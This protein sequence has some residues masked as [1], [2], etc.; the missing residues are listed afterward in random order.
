MFI[1]GHKYIRS[2]VKERNQISN[3]HKVVLH[4]LITRKTKGKHFYNTQTYFTKFHKSFNI[5]K[6][7][8]RL[9]PVFLTKTCKHGAHVN[10]QNKLVRKGQA[11]KIKSLVFLFGKLPTTVF[12]MQPCICKSVFV[13][14]VHCCVCIK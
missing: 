13:H 2:T 8:E 7:G 4:V 9:D 1:H 14:Q 5:L 12:K 10:P 3:N 11:A 6:F